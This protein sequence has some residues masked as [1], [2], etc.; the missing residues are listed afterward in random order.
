MQCGAKTRSG[1][2]CKSFAMANG[3]CRMHGGKAPRGH[4]LPQTTHGRYSKDLPTRLAARYEEAANDPDLLQLD[5]EIHLTDAMIR[6]RLSTLDTGESGRLWKALKQEWTTFALARRSGDTA[7]MTESLAQI[8]ALINR[9]V[10]DW[11]ARQEVLDMVERRRKLVDSEGKR[12]V[13][14]QQMITPDRAM[15]LVSALADTVMRHVSDADI[16]AAI[17]RDVERLITRPVPGD[18]Q[19]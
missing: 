19:S 18:D 13:Q 17:A 10:A 2:P 8:E 16:R 3:R 4:A 9:G 14:M 6:E 1:E 12:R 7:G 5:S 11:S 15:L